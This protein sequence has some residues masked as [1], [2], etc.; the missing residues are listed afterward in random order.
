MVSLEEQYAILT[1]QPS[2]KPQSLS[3]IFRGETIVTALK[4]IKKF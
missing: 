4:T 3:Y 1:A 2:H